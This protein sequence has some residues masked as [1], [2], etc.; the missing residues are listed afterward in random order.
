MVA[1][2]S[3]LTPAGGHEEKPPRDPQPAVADAPDLPSRE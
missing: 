2:R 1:P 3:E